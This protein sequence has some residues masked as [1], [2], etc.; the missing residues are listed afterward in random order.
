[1][2]ARRCPGPW[3]ELVEAIVRPEI[4]EADENI[5]KVGLGLDVVQFAGLYQRR[6]DGPIFRTIIVTGEESIL[7]RQSLW[8]HRTLDDV[9]V[10][11]V[12]RC[13]SPSAKKAAN[14]IQDLLRF[15]VTPSL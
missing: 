9:G 4:D 10:G 7:E 14:T 6:D 3:E 2:L 13:P 15:C 11:T 8:A 1:L 12:V 5:G